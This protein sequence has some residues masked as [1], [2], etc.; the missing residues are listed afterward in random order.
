MFTLFPCSGWKN[1]GSQTRNMLNMASMEV[2]VRFLSIWV[3][4][5]GLDVCYK[6][7]TIHTNFRE[8]L[9]SRFQN[10]REI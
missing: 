5:I 9:F 4:Y 2:C 6:T 10:N 1:I 3:R 8:Y 7:L